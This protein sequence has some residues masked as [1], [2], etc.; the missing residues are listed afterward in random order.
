[1]SQEVKTGGRRAGS[2]NT[3][4]TQAAVAGYYELLKS[5]ADNGDI[6]AAAALIELHERRCCSEQPENKR[7]GL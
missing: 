5:Y 2:R 3:K 7:H 4:P 6:R 1:M